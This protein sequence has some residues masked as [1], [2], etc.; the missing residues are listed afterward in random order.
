MFSSATVCPVDVVFIIDASK[1]I[2]NRDFQ[3]EKDLVK[4]AAGKMDMAP[5]KSRAAIILFSKTVSVNVTLGQ[6][7][8]YEEFQR[9][10][11][12][13]DHDENADYSSDGIHKSLN[14]ATDVFSGAR[15][16][17]RR[18]AILFS[19]GF[20]TFH[21]VKENPSESLKEVAGNLRKLGV[22][23]LVV[24]T[25]L[26]LYY[27]QTAVL[28]MVIERKEDIVYDFKLMLCK[29]SR[30]LS[31]GEYMSE[32]LARGN[33]GY[34]IHVH[35]TPVPVSPC[36]LCLLRNIT[37]GHPMLRKNHISP[38]SRHLERVSRFLH[39]LFPPPVDFPP[40]LLPGSLI[41]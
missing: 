7:P 9:A 8:T 2:S 25:G 13:L 14:A 11:D 6:R 4:L 15:T 24:V 38:S 12:S 26:E 30:V 27:R 33:R 29:L 17:V 35:C 5:G 1:S 36:L 40:H 41:G 31:C 20:Q 18:I 21:G 10:V 19:T 16:S 22:R 32:F 23:V 28:K 37:Q 34:K 39:S 3:I